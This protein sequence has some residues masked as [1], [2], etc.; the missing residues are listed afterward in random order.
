MKLCLRPPCTLKLP[1]RLPRTPALEHAAQWW[2]LESSGRPH[3]QTQRS[4]EG[5]AKGDGKGGPEIPA[6]RIS[7]GKTPGGGEDR[8]ETATAVSWRQLSH[9][10]PRLNPRRPLKLGAANRA[11]PMQVQ[12]HRDHGQVASHRPLLPTWAH[13]SPC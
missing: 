1:H 5:G 13:Q 8:F 9:T 7:S 12:H 2:P 11:P 6:T 10:A 4:Q 3:R